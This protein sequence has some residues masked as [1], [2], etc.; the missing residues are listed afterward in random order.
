MAIFLPPPP[1]VNPSPPGGEC[2][3]DFDGCSAFGLVNCVSFGSNAIP[4]GGLCFFSP[5][6]P[7]GNNGGGGAGG[8][9]RQLEAQIS[10]HWSALEKLEK[11]Y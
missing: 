10:Y 5:N 4:D 2:E 7:T 11:Y 9:R 8:V 6:G 3:G 1:G